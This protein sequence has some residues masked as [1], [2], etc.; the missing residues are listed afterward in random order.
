MFSNRLAFALL[1]AACITAAGAG[2]YFASRQNAGPGAPAVTTASPAATAIA[3][4]PVQETEAF[5]SSKPTSRLPVATAAPVAVASP[6]AD[7]RPA[8]AAPVRSVKTAGTGRTRDVSPQALERPWPT[9]ATANAAPASVPIS[10]PPATVAPALEPPSPV[11]LDETAAAETARA[12]DPPQKTFEELVVPAD[13]VIGLQTE[14]SLSTERAR[15]EDRVDARVTRDVRVGDKVAIPSGS[16]AIGSVMQVERGGKFRDRP[17]LGIRFH[18]IVLADGSRLPISTDTIYR[19]GA[20]PQSAQK[21][22]GA[23]VGGAILGAILGGAKGAAIGAVGG[24]GGGAAV[25]E[26]GERGTATLPAGTPMTVRILSPVTVS[27]EK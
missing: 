26:A 25:V 8:A 17:R 21:I 10:T 6:R 7:A 3:E 9:S 24:A 11:R 1:A 12:P 13:S 18:T 15:V 16:R 4:R 23:A 14:T 27:V 5:V 22:G 20:A 2:G 19:E